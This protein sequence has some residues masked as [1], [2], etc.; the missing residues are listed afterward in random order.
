MQGKFEGLY[1]PLLR[2]AST[3]FPHLCLVEDWLVSE[4]I[5]L[6]RVTGTHVPTRDEL[7]SALDNVV[8]CPAGT[9]MQ[10]KRLLSLP[11]RLSWSMAT[12]IISHIRT[13]LDTRAPRHTQE[14][15]KQVSVVLQPY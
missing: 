13:I 3:Q 2:L 8:T 9:N 14:L 11:P 4:Q 5:S 12:I 1:P 15:Y 10:L 7:Q 6:S